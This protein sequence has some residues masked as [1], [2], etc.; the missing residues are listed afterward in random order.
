MT[1]PVRFVS[2]GNYSIRT[3]HISGVSTVIKSGSVES[4]QYQ[5]HII[6]NGYALTEYFPSEVDAEAE[7]DRIEKAIGIQAA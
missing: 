7:A 5:V 4:V 1:A 3:D 2:F 6:V